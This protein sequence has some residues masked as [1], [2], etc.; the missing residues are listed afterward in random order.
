MSQR[1]RLELEE[2]EAESAR[3]VA[4]DVVLAECVLTLEQL[5]AG[6]MKSLA[7]ADVRARFAAKW[8]AQDE[9]AA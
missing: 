3:F 7:L 5:N 9:P 1:Q 4:S 8:A 6:T 2:V